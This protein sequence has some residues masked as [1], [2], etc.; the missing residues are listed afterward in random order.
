MKAGSIA[1]SL[2]LNAALH[3]AQQPDQHL[4]RT[5][6]PDVTRLQALQGLDLG[7]IVALLS[8]WPRTVQKIETMEQSI[9]KSCRTSGNTRGADVSRKNRSDR[10][11][12]PGRD[13]GRVR[14][15]HAWRPTSFALSNGRSQSSRPSTLPRG[16]LAGPRKHLASHSRACDPSHLRSVWSRVRVGRSRRRFRR[17]GGIDPRA[18]SLDRT[19]RSTRWLLVRRRAPDH[20][21]GRSSSRHG[22]GERRAVARGVFRV[23]S[24]A[25]HRAC[26]ARGSVSRCLIHGQRVRRAA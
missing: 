22:R 16:R 24:G 8:T 7:L 5:E 6:R 13:S 21:P 12:V 10:S 25:T 2:A 9:A 3:H 11:A 4:G 19:G 14:Q 26:H 20:S 17:Q 1:A 15:D 18:S 23:F